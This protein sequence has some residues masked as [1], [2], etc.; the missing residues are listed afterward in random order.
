M[1]SRFTEVFQ[2]YDEDKKGFLSRFEVIF[3]LFWKK[4]IWVLSTVAVEAVL[5]GITGIS[6]DEGWTIFQISIFQHFVPTVRAEKDLS[7]KR[8]IPKC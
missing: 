8:R 1:G 2:S 6:S 7:L 5:P 4:G 3:F